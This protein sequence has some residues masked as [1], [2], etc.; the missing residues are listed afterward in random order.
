MV[1]V[2]ALGAMIG[3]LA[4]FLSH[5]WGSGRTRGP[6]AGGAGTRGFL[7]GPGDLGARPR[8]SRWCKR[9]QRHPGVVRLVHAASVISGTP[10]VSVVT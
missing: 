5:T 10:S 2:F 7:I 4:L 3:L 1:G 9:D 6:D 8:L